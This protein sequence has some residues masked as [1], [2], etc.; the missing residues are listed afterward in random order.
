MPKVKSRSIRLSVA[1]SFACLAALILLVWNYRT[2]AGHILSEA[3]AH[4]QWEA[5]RATGQIDSSLQ[6]MVPP[7]QALANRLGSGRWTGPQIE[8]L[9]EQ[10]MSENPFLFGVGVAFRP[11]AFDS[12]QRLFAPYF[13]RSGLTYLDYDYTER[14]FYMLPMESGGPVWQEPHYGQASQARIANYTAPFYITDSATGERRPAGVIFTTLTLEDY[15]ELIGS[16]DLGKTGYGFIL[17]HQGKVIAH[18]RRDYLGRQLTEIARQRD[19]A[20]LAELARKAVLGESGAVEH[21]DSI[22]GRSSWIFFQ[23]IPT[24]GWTMGAVFFHQEMAREMADLK[25]RKVLIVAMTMALLLSLGAVDYSRRQGRVEPR[26]WRL[27]FLSAAVLLIGVAALIFMTIAEPDKSGQDIITPLTGP[28][29][30][31]RFFEQIEAT[32]YEPDEAPL[33]IPTGVFVQS[34][35]FSSPTDV[36]LTG[37][38]WQKCTRGSQDADCGFVMPENVSG[39]ISEI[40]RRQQGEIEVVGWYFEATLRQSF[41]YT[42]YPFDRKHVW[43]R[44]RHSEMDRNAVLVPDLE[45]YQLPNPL[46]LPGMESELVVPGWAIEESYFGVRSHGYNTDFGIGGPEQGHRPELY[47]NMILRRKP[48]GVLITH[49]IPLTVVAAL[50][51]GMMKSVSGREG[52]DGM[53]FSFSG[54]LAQVSGLFFVVILSHIQLQQDVAGGLVYVGYFYFLMYLMILCTA[55]DAYLVATNSRLFLVRYRNNLLPKV[56]YWPFIAGAA[57]LVTL[58][59]FSPSAGPR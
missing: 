16:L 49:F 41:N 38:I 21:T 23:P 25:V 37:K 56:L 57:F 52:D 14:D 6:K 24:A 30:R 5:Q 53:D 20:A 11:F 31:E 35:R 55:V 19:D 7:N 45:S 42:R 59:I 22:S 50:L 46:S 9:L 4:A 54:I 17:S 44:L 51:F 58:A 40:Y 27:A 33:Y 18:P 47:F 36:T 2:E 15:R 29:A 1:L 26:L 34:L 28:S 32:H 12:R 13:R 48:L 43:I 8:Q 39:K 3:R 10:T